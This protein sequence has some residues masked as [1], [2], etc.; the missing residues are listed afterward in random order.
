MTVAIY[1]ELT[2]SYMALQELQGMTVAIHIVN[3]ELHGITRVTRVT[4]NDCGYIHRVNMELHVHVHGITGVTTNDSGYTYT[5][6]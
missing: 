3:M 2:W 4:R 6:S 1:I 5:W